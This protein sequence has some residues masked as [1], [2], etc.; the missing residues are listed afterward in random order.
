[1][2]QK[3]VYVVEVQCK[4]T[5]NPIIIFSSFK[6]ALIHYNFEVK[7]LV[8]DGAKLGD[9]MVCSKTHQFINGTSKSGKAIDVSVY[10]KLLF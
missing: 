4:D 8:E 7:S 1:M 10:Q 2:S 3:K 9:N 5:H 6:K